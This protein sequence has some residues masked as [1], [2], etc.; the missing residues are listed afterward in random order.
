[1][2]TFAVRRTGSETGHC[3]LITYDKGPR[4][5]WKSKEFSVF[6]GPH[7][8]IADA[9]ADGQLLFKM[10]SAADDA[11]FIQ[12]AATI[13]CDFSAVSAGSVITIGG[14]ILTSVSGART[15]GSDDFQIDG[16]I[17]DDTTLAAEVAAAINDPLNSFAAVVVNNGLP[18]ALNYKGR[19][20]VRMLARQN[21]EIMSS[22]G[23]IRFAGGK[24]APLAVKKIA[25]NGTLQ[26]LL[27]SLFQFDQNLGH[28]GVNLV[29]PTS[30][31]IPIRPIDD[32][33]FR[34]GHCAPPHGDM[35]GVAA[36]FSPVGFDV[37]IGEDNQRVFS[38]ILALRDRKSVV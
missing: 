27:Q 29:I 28:M 2:Q 13:T 16:G 4:T 31:Q 35:A 33:L 12:S 36:F 9:N 10:E 11:E 21:T 38:R 18:L 19:E 24:T 25:E 5:V 30:Q 26:R 22:R 20:G 1:M 34:A 32:Q 3:E 7:P 17:S 8:V 23:G 37:P 14:V 6:Q 15:P